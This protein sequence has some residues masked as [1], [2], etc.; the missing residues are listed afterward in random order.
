[1]SKNIFINSNFNNYLNYLR[2]NKINFS[3]GLL[4][5]YVL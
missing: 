3:F 5:G 1:M 4:I 2:N